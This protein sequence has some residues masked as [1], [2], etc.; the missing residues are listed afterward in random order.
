MAQAHA[1]N[2]HER[3]GKNM[4]HVLRHAEKQSAV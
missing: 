4:H 1:G 3:I 2:G